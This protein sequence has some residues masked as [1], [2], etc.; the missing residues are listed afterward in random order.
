MQK[1]GQEKREGR[2]LSMSVPARKGERHTF[3]VAFGP[4]MWVQDIS[5][6]LQGRYWRRIY[7]LWPH[8]ASSTHRRRSYSCDCQEESE[9]LG[10]VSLMGRLGPSMLKACP[11]VQYFTHVHRQGTCFPFN[12]TACFMES[13]ECQGSRRYSTPK[14]LFIVVFPSCG[15]L[16]RLLSQPRAGQLDQL[17]ASVL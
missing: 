12:L 17:S 16:P 3:C 9:I 14:H 11:L 4:I 13:W 5:L 2:V 7:G 10:H 6:G 1:R 8:F 15:S